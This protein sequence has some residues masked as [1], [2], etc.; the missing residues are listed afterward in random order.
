MKQKKFEKMSS[1]ECPRPTHPPPRHFCTPS[2]PKGREESIQKPIKTQLQLQHFSTASAPPP[3]PKAQKNPFKNRPTAYRL[4]TAGPNP[5]HPANRN[6]SQRYQ[7][8]APPYNAS[9]QA[10]QVPEERSASPTASR[11]PLALTRKVRKGLG[12][13]GHAHQTT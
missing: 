3:N 10:L 9:P 1:Y 4:P 8:P 7:P 6:R 5:P 11:S 12:W 13:A 2:E